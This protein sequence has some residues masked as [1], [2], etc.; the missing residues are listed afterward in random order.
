MAEP[1]LHSGVSNLRRDSGRG[2]PAG[3][4]ERGGLLSG[5]SELAGGRKAELRRGRR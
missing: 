5:V 1:W 2:Q 4:R 3:R